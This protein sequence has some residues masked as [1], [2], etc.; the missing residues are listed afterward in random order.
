[1]CIGI[2][3]L[4]NLLISFSLLRRTYV[5]FFFIRR[6]NASNEKIRKINDD[7]VQ[8][9]SL[10][11]VPSPQYITFSHI[12]QNSADKY[13]SH[14]IILIESPINQTD[15]QQWMLE[16]FAQFWQFHLFNALIVYWSTELKIVT[17]TP[18]S[19][20]VLIHLPPTTMRYDQLFW[21]K[22]QNLNRR[23]LHVSLF[24][25]KTRAVFH[26]DGRQTGTDGYLTNVM[27][28]KMNATLRLLPPTDGFD[29]GEFL[30]NGSVVGSLAQIVRHDVDVSFNTRFLRLA[31]FQGKVQI[32][33]PIGRDDICILVAKAGFASNVNNIFRA[34]SSMV[35]L[36]T[37]ISLL[38][39]SLSFTV[40]YRIQTPTDR[41]ITHILFNF[42]SWNLAQPIVKL[43]QHWASKILIG[44][45][46]V[47]GLLITSSYQGNLTSNL[48]SRPTL[49]EINTIRQL[50]Q[51]AYEILTFG[52]YVDLL[53]NF[54][55]QTG[56]YSRLKTR[57]RGVPQKEMAQLIADNNVKFAYANKYHI[58]HY[59]SNLKSHIVRGRPVYNNMKECPVPYLVAYAVVYGSPYLQR[60][61]IIL[62]RLQESGLIL[63]WDEKS[64]GDKSKGGGQ[65]TNGEPVP[66]TVDHVQSAFYILFLGLILSSMVF[67][68]ELIRYKYRNVIK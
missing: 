9:F 67:C 44:V 18:F 8:T 23:P 38:A 28:Q 46:I 64:A 34:F 45:W 58:N 60:I 1:M 31:Q 7:Y 22:A 65:R 14:F 40:I 55:N 29:I 37:L 56:S 4:N 61:N 13:N 57:I 68:T 33:F 41:Q 59:Q 50:E 3:T 52:R 20:T 48:I 32:T 54:L 26:S 51:S 11:I 21:D 62:R 53:Q 10:T 27:S 36:F 24:S 6:Y 39:M 66:L 35:W 19:D 49:P 2:E 12:K 42:Y 5:F 47:Y 63:Y 16:T 30:K 25:E 43:P 17:Y 15:T